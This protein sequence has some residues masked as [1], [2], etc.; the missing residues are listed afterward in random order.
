MYERDLERIQ[1]QIRMRSD[2]CHPVL[3]AV[4]SLIFSSYLN[5]RTTI[6]YLLVPVLLTYLFFVFIF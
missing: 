5:S 1:S 4:H 2:N 6:R 3:A